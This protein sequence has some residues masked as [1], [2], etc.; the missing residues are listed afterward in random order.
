MNFGISTSVKSREVQ[1]C[2][3]A[4]LDHYLDS[5]LV[6][7]ICAE[8]A[9][10]R[11]K[12]LEGILSS[13]EFETIKQQLKQRL[14]VLTPHAT[15]RGGRRKN[16]EAIPS[17]LS[18]YDIDHIANP[19]ERWERIAPRA[20]ELGILLAH[21]TPSC[22]GL[23]LL[24]L[25]PQ[26]MDLPQAQQWMASQLGDGQY[27]AVC[28]DLARCSFL[29]PREY[30]LYFDSERLFC[31]SGENAD[32]AEGADERRNH[33]L[34]TAFKENADDA[35]G[36]DERRG[37]HGFSQMKLIDTDEKSVINPCESVV[38]KDNTDERRGKIIL[39]ASASE[40]SVVCVL[41]KTVRL[42]TARLRTTHLRTTSKTTQTPARRH[43][44]ASPIQTSSANWRTS[45]A[46]SPSAASGTTSSSR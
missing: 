25:I 29:V 40:V 17:G 34:A 44:K 42:R 16:A 18:M 3:P 24:F 4:L 28:K 20:E 41:L 15:F 6:A 35:E 13:D 38:E 36:T 10:A 45:W 21:I 43:T 22:E 26:G 11:E 9:D 46:A 5:P 31:A 39:R 12:K 32:D 7:R 8:I 2:T 33:G 14:P 30:L 37:N 1:L 27:D 19:G 23:R